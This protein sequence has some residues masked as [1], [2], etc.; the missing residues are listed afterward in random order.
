MNHQ[1]WTPF[2]K[3]CPEPAGPLQPPSV[4]GAH[5]VSGGRSLEH[6]HP[7]ESTKTLA[8]AELGVERAR[9]RQLLA[10]PV[11]SLP[12]ARQGT[13]ITGK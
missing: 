3:S 2:L 4:T 11:N 6:Q 12:V 13:P 1:L 7:Y 8:M 9:P 5:G 10:L